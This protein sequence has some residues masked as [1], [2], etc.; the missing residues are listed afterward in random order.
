MKRRQAGSMPNLTKR[1]MQGL[2]RI[3][4]AVKLIVVAVICL[5]IGVTARQLFDAY[6]REIVPFLKEKRVEAETYEVVP[7]QQQIPLSREP[8]EPLRN[9]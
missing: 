6:G 3:L 5:F 7:P 9:R 8:V 2:T 1:A 4:H